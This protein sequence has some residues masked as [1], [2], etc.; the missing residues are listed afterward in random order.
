MEGENRMKRMFENDLTSENIKRALRESNNLVRQIEITM[1]AA[2]SNRKDPTIEAI[3]L[4]ALILLHI[5]MP[6]HSDGLMKKEIV[7]I[8]GL[9]LFGALCEVAVLRKLDDG[10]FRLDLSKR[11]E[12]FLRS[13]S[14][15]VISVLEFM[16]K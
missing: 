15:V 5:A 2:S 11:Q 3:V 6:P 9:T 8:T 7:S 4:G 10:R 16:K 12:D 1:K 14:E 13:Y